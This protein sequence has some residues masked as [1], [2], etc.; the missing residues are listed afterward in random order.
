MPGYRTTRRMEDRF[1]VQWS[2]GVGV[3]E[4]AAAA[5]V[6]HGT[7]KG[8]V[9]KRGGVKPASSS[10]GT[11]LTLDD[12]VRIQAGVLAGQSNAEIARAIGRHRSTVGAELKRNAWPSA[13]GPAN[14]R[15]S[16][17][18]LSAQKRAEA[19][20]ARPKLR[21]LDQNPVL[22]EAVQQKLKQDWSPEQISRW[23][24]RIHGK[25]PEMTISH[26]A[27]YQ[28]IYVNSAGGLR[29]ELTAALRTGRKL[30]KPQRRP[31]QRRGRIA[32]MVPIVERPE[33]ALG[34]A[35]PG[36]WEGDLIMGANKHRACQTVCVRA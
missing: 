26:E 36:H 31:E 5:G 24:Y 16:Y 22:H 27:I 17:N 8:W 19:Q 2:R 15:R 12:R 23:L 18:A 3:E 20:R 29:R 1:W 34:R 11:D 32:D 4:A 14:Q 21:K 33:E 28:C 7:A 35:I 10:S 30:R 13:R 25:D 9:R 6:S